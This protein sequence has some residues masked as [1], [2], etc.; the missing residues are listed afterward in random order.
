MKNKYIPLVYGDDIYD[1]IFDLKHYGNIVFR[2][3][4]IWTDK[5]W[6][7][8]IVFNVNQGTSEL[9]AGLVMV[10][11]VPSPTTHTIRYMIIKY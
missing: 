4:K 6:S 10:K 2:P 7:D 11:D 5:S 9:N 1:G 8:L 3:T